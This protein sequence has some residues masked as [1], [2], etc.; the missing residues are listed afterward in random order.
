[1]RKGQ[2]TVGIIVG[3]VMGVFLSNIYSCSM[4]VD[5]FG[6]STV[7]F[8]DLP[9]EVQD[10]I[11]FWVEHDMV[12]TFTASYDTSQLAIL[13]KPEIISFDGS[14]SLKCNE[15]GP[16]VTNKVLTRNS[17]GK[18]FK[19]AGNAPEPIIIHNGNTIIP[20]EYNILTVWKPN[21]TFT[22]YKLH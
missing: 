21:V 17:D 12:N 18:K 11:S 22:V 9:K 5:S 4:E 15:W 7:S 16:W 8:T 13:D 20:D 1:M 10:S 2:H 19:L 3:A 6:G 14:Y